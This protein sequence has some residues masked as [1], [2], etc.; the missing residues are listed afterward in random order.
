MQIKTTL[1]VGSL[2]RRIEAFMGMAACKVWT[3]HNEWDSTRGSPVFT[4]DGKYTARSWT[5]WT[6]GFFVGLAILQFDL[7]EDSSF[8]EMGRAKTIRSMPPH[9]SH[10]GVHDHGFNIVSTFGNL[11][12][13]MKEGRIP[14]NRPELDSY[15]L[16]LKVSGAIQAA[17][18]SPT[19]LGDGYIYSFNGP[20]SLFADTIRSLLVPDTGSRAWSRVDGR[21]GRKDKPPQTSP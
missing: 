6:Q 19:S 8:L 14:H 3:V 16:A 4:V 21:R 9:V 1:S 13:L 11:R 18:Y 15:E 7:T 2:S 12:R 17:R 10:T 20:H 5:D